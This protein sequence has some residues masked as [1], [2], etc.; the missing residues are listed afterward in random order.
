MVLVHCSDN[1]NRQRVLYALSLYNTASFTPQFTQLYNML[2]FVHNE[3]I[4]PLRYMA[5]VL[6]VLT[7]PYV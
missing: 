4:K 6:Q 3:E 2:V 7:H 1:F 5:V